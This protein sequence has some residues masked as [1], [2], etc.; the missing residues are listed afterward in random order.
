MRYEYPPFVATSRRLIDKFGMDAQLVQF[1]S[2]G[3]IDPDRPWG[4]AT[5]TASAVPVRV[6]MQKYTTLERNLTSIADRDRKVLMAPGDAV[7]G[8]GDDLVIDALAYDV[9]SVEE[10][11]PGGVPLLYTLQVR[12]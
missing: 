12:A 1:A 3:P 4:G 8:T 6:V 2:G 5:A 11:A 10:E 7:P 9:I